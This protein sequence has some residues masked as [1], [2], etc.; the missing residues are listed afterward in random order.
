MNRSRKSQHELDRWLVQNF[1][2]FFFF[3]SV[4]YDEKGNVEKKKQLLS[5]QINLKNSWLP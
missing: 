5:H 2:S 4:G 1:T 3:F